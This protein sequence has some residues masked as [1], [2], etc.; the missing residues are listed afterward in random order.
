MSEINVSVENGSSV[1]L[2]TAGK[3]CDKDI[4]VTTTGNTETVETQADMLSQII[5]I[6]DEPSGG[7]LYELT[8]PTSFDANNKDYINTGVT[9]LAKDRNFTIAFVVTEASSGSKSSNVPVFHCLAEE[10]PYYGLSLQSGDRSFNY[11]YRFGGW[12][13]GYGNSEFETG[14]TDII[15]LS[16]VKYAMVIS[17]SKGIDSF[18]IT[19]QIEGQ[20]VQTITLDGIG[21]SSIYTNCVNPSLHIGCYQTI[22]GNQGRYWT[23]DIHH[24]IITESV[25]TEEEI[26]RYLTRLSA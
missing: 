23:G 1:K 18:N 14:Y 2:K 7:V 15:M 19:Y 4:L 6:L 17:H 11:R 10:N 8:T 12:I 26:N 20:E 21:V 16:G 13:G 5:E 24:F 9:L 22:S 3:Y 25:F